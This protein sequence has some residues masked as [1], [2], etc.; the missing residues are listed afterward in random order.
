MTEELLTSTTASFEVVDEVVD[1][2]QAHSNDKISARSF[3]VYRT[4]PN[5][6]LNI[7]S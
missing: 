5:V 7:E 3:D 4:K 6:L 2:G 1:A